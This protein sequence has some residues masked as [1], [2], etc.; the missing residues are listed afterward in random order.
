M[1][2]AIKSLI[3]SLDT[4]LEVNDTVKYKGF[5]GMYHV[6]TVIESNGTL[7]KLKEPIS[8]EIFLYGKEVNNFHSIQKDM[9]FTLAVSAIQRLDEIVQEQQKTIELLLKNINASFCP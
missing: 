2:H 7:H 6:T 5:D 9:V 4:D 8:G 3:F 1:I